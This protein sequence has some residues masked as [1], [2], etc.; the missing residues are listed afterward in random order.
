M[1]YYKVSCLAGL[2]VVL[3]KRGGKRQ[4]VQ[5]VQRID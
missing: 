3:N 2:R 5:A 4:K 1:L